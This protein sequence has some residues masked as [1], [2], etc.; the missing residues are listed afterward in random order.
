MQGATF[1]ELYG[2]SGMIENYEAVFTVVRD[3][4]PMLSWP[5]MGGAMPPSVEKMF[6]LLSRLAADNGKLMRVVQSEAFRIL[7]TRPQTWCHGDINPT[8]AWKRKS[9]PSQILLA[10]WQLARMSPPVFDMWVNPDEVLC[11]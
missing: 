3:K 1:A 10:D 7:N 11:C 9:D 8:N 6:A 5:E 2:L 4:M